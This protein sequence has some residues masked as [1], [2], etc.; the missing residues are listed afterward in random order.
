MLFLF[1]FI[2]MTG[3]NTYKVLILESKRQFLRKMFQWQVQAL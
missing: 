2:P 3:L 1:N